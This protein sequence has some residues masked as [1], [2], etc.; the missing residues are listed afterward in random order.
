M[1]A[2]DQLAA[3]SR[4]EWL[5]AP[6]PVARVVH[7]TTRLAPG[8]L[9]V[10]LRGER[11]D[12]HEFVAEAFRRGAAAALVRRDWTPP[13]GVGPLLRVADPLRALGDLA[14]GYRRTLTAR[15][16]A[17]TGS[18][19][20]TTAKEL[21]AAV[22]STAGD[23]TRTQGNWNNI[24]GLPLSILAMRPTDTFGVFEVGMNHP[25]ELAPL[26]DILR[27]DWGVITRIAAVH[28]EFFPS[29]EAIA[30][31]KATVVRALPPDGLA[32]LA[33]DE[34]WFDLV[35][36]Q[37]RARVATVAWSGDADYVGAVLPDRPDWI[38]V[39]ERTGRCAEYPMPGPGE[40]LRRN[41]LRAIAVGRE[42]ALP[43]ER[44]AAGL[45]QYAPPPMRWETAEIGGVLWIN[46]AYNASPLSMAAALRTFRETPASGRRWLVLG[47]MRELGDRAPAEHEALGRLV[48][49]GDW[50]GLVTVGELG[51]AIARAARDAGWPAERVLAAATP[52]EAVA[53]LRERLA[54]G[55]AVL[56][57]GSRG[58][59]VERVLESWRAAV[60][61]PAP[62]TGDH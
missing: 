6:A 60:G 45:R 54:P 33:A 18:L 44:I 5:G 29:E 57:K 37:T 50:A 61:E 58:E 43:P 36:S 59:R 49:T 22:L 23:V 16:I 20:K 15:F 48:A 19:G 13:P 47:G 24:I 56:L 17:I 25:G 3:W 39:R 4:G 34:P 38:S 27:P 10:A 30:M 8:D 28:I 31:E 40:P 62:A 32:V 26:C 12:G 35:R 52:A 42:L 1:F 2:P 9:F 53:W 41:A 51:A 11:R 21:I 7:D 55:D 46:D 14:R